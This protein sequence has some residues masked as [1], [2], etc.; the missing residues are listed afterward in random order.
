[1]QR[2]HVVMSAPKL[3]T[4]K[5]LECENHVSEEFFLWQVLS[6]FQVVYRTEPLG[7]RADELTHHTIL[8]FGAHIHMGF[9]GPVFSLGAGHHTYSIQTDN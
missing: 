8:D 6:V 3:S 1:M 9:L 7:P 2:R 4:I 5:Y